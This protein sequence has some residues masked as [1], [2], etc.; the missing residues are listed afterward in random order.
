MRVVPYAYYDGIW[1]FRDS[2]MAALYRKILQDGNGY[3]AQDCSSD[4]EFVS[5]MKENI[6]GIAQEGWDTAGVAWL[7]DIEGKKAQG[8]FIVFREYWGKKSV[9]VTKAL[10]EYFLTIPGQD[11]FLIDMLWGF[12]ATENRLA[13]R[14]LKKCGVIT[15]GELPCGLWDYKKQQPVSAVVSYITRRELENGR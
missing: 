7:T 5:S 10:I 8:H 13:V 2:D 15:I 9:E 6:V 1:S 12:T 3:T 14:H 4:E 11:G